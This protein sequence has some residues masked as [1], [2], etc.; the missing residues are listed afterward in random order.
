M[1]LQFPGQYFDRE[2]GTHY[3]YFRD[4]NPQTGKYIQRGPIGLNGGI[5]VYNYAF[6]SPLRFYDPK[7]EVNPALILWGVA[8]VLAAMTGV[9]AD[10]YTNPNSAYGQMNNPANI[11][12][13]PSLVGLPD[14][15]E[16]VQRW[17]DRGYAQGCRDRTG[18]RVN[19]NTLREANRLTDI[20]G[21]VEGQMEAIEDQRRYHDKCDQK[22]P[23]Q[24]KTCEWV[25]FN[26]AEA[27]ACLEARK[28]WVD[29]WVD[30]DIRRKGHLNYLEQLRRQ[31]NTASNQVQQLC[32]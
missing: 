23:Y 30:F 9:T 16:E 3:N 15:R 18:A 29:K 6:N 19:K 31:I 11:P 22:N 13:Y 26:L 8:A 1:N 12:T 17:R 28:S 20:A 24:P 4:Y 32:K 27:E 14:D 2:T 5:N 10:Y 25:V 21:V 7:G